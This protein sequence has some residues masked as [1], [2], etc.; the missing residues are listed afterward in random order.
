MDQNIIQLNPALPQVPAVAR[1]SFTPAPS[2][3]SSHAGRRPSSSYPAVAGSEHELLQDETSSDAPQLKKSTTVFVITSVA[4]VTA[5]SSM[6]AGVV[7]VAIPAI[8][9]DVN[10]PHS[11]L[12]W[13]ASIYALVSGCTLLLCGSATDV[14]GSRTMY[15]LG[16]A[17]QAGFVLACGMSQTGSQLI[18]FRALSGLA[19]SLCLPS[20]TCII[21]NAFETGRR[22][23]AA[24]ASM[25]GGQPLGFAIGLTLGGVFT[26]TIGWRWS[27]YLGTIL[28]TAVGLLAVFTVPKDEK[29][30]S[31]IRWSAT[32]K[33]V[34]LVGA[35]IASGSLGGLSYVFALV[36]TV[37]TRPCGF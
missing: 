26:D 5:I 12:L 29:D 1:V 19:N 23:N 18:L 31:P 6:L 34:D 22:R 25:G 15:L 28:T 32:F 11:L 7:T 8:A 2:E 3:R 9:E 21:T 35:G 4:S 20:A 33:Q 16:C 36:Y 14:F 37:E 10:L 24:F 30:R 13:P 17:A 27:F